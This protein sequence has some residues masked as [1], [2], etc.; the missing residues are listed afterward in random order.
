VQEGANTRLSRSRVE[1]PHLALNVL[2]A[3]KRRTMYA[4]EDDY[5]F[6]ST[7]LRGKKPCSATILVRNY[8]RPAAIRAG[9][10]IEKPDELF[11]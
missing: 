3:W 11:S 9:I 10:L 6:P 5:V 2:A 1:V 8:L 7:K 4:A